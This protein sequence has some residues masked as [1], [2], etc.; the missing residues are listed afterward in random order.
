MDRNEGEERP[1]SE[2]VQRT[3]V[4]DEDRS[5]LRAVQA[6]SVL[7]PAGDVRHDLGA[8]ARHL[9]FLGGASIP[10]ATPSCSFQDH[11]HERKH[12]SEDVVHLL[13]RT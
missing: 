8:N 1:Q 5:G 12:A 7:W 4:C 11:P 2:K 10:S 9:A 6:A 13:R 3:I